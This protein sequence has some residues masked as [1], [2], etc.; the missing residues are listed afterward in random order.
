ML[1]YWI[2]CVSILDWV[3]RLLDWLVNMLGQ[4]VGLIVLV[5][6]IGCDCI[7]H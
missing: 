5:V 2:G 3:A 7:L 6:L 1:V 4:Y